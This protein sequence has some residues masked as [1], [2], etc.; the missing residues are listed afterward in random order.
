V[1]EKYSRILD[2]TMRN[3]TNSVV[4]DAASSNGLNFRDDHSK[5][6]NVVVVVALLG[7]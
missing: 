2:I 7:D 3:G 6:N 5:S 4:G 1:T